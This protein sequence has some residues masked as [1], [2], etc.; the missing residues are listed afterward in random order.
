[1]VREF[2]CQKE[3]FRHLKL[4]VAFGK[5]CIESYSRVVESQDETKRFSPD[6]AGAKERQEIP[7]PGGADNM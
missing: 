3:I 2:F 4:N 6:D 1:M 7:S 5:F